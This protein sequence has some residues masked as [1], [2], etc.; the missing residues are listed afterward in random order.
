M[1]MPEIDNTQAI[2][3]K[4]EP[5]LKGLSNH[6]LSILNKMVVERIRLM[7]RAG[8]LVSMSQFTIGDRVSWSGSDGIMRTGIIIRLNHK[9]ASVKIG[10]EGYWKVSPQLLRK[11][12]TVLDFFWTALI[13]DFGDKS[14]GGVG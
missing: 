9:T 1:T 6:E 5:L 14:L 3:N 12:E 10:N 8:S 13:S 7:H 4:F 2:I 11:E